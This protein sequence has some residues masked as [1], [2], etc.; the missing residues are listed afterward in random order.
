MIGLSWN[1]SLGRAKSTD[2]SSPTQPGSAQ[3]RTA[4][5][6]AEARRIVCDSIIRFRRKMSRGVARIFE[7]LFARFRNLIL[8]SPSARVLNLRTARNNSPAAPSKI[9]GRKLAGRGGAN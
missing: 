8:T 5:A 1:S 6:Q 3:Q 2:P 7:N 4:E 9:G